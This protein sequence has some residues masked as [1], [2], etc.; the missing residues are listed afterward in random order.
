MQNTDSTQAD[1][2]QKTENTEQPAAPASGFGMAGASAEQQPPAE[3]A[4]APAPAPE[5]APAPES[6]PAPTATVAEAAPSE[7]V[8]PP[9]AETPE[10]AEEAPAPA[11]PAALDEVPEDKDK[12]M[13][14][15]MG[16][17][18]KKAQPE[19][20]VP[21]S[22]S[23]AKMEKAKA[24]A[25]KKMGPAGKGALNKQKIQT[26][27]YRDKF[28][29]LVYLAL[30]NAVIIALILIA[31]IFYMFQTQPE[32]RYFATTVD[33]RILK[34]SPLDEASIP[35]AELNTWMI[36]SVMETLSFGYHDY[37]RR[38][39]DSTKYFTKPGW[40]SFASMLQEMR[41][42]EEIEKKQLVVSGEPLG[43]PVLV[44]EGIVNGRYRWVIDIN[45]R[46]SLQG[47]SVGTA[48]PLRL[49]LTIERVPILENVKGIAIERWSVRAK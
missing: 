33:G 21:V 30:A 18:D 44:Q 11:E 19:T 38:L 27:F 39:Q 9:T 23:V 36:Q 31:M 12:A 28:H 8:T 45:F 34:L 14:K 2:Q 6:P 35:E 16:G 48:R 4:A 7:Q 3:A 24:S 20:L 41:L 40:T 29:N 1:N 32:N 15:Q 22:K 26:E 42:I 5:A 43:A 17:D 49:R 47:K 46:V 37:Q 13:E 25:E 10:P